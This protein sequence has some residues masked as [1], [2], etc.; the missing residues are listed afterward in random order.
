MRNMKR[1]V[2]LA[3]TC[4]AVILW[5]AACSAKTKVVTGTK[6]R[7][8]D[9][10]KVYRD[11]TREI[12]VD[13]K[14][15]K[16]MEFKTVDGYCP[17]CGD[18]IVTVNQLQHQ[19]CPVCGA[20]LGTVTKQIQIEKKLADTVPK[21]TEVAVAC[22]KPRCAKVGRLHA[23]YN[24]DWNACVAVADQQIGFGFS[25]EMV[26]ESWGPP[27]RTEKIGNAT[28]WYYDAGYVTIGASGKVVE[29]KQ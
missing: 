28:R 17:A 4:A 26:R 7:C 8:K 6:Y 14:L 2:T 13:R 5:V 10:G 20:D 16:G 19:K 11:D 15:A 29:V 12:E 21:E 22:D 27:K 9:C 3:V 18:K 24:W 25:E 1:Y 23:K